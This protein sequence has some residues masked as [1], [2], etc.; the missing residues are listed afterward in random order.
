MT[1]VAQTATRRN[2]GGRYS[3]KGASDWYKAIEAENLAKVDAEQAALAALTAAAKEALPGQDARIDK[4]AALVAEHAVWPLTSGSYLVASQTDAQAAYL[5]QRPN[6]QRNGH[7][8][9]GWLCDC[10]DFQ[11]RGG[12]CG[13]IAATM[14]TVRM[15]ATY[16]PS[17][18]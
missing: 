18:N 4:G 2:E 9:H 15:G 16:E 8:G 10:K 3:A 1:N 13:H 6:D 12:L 17:Y 11:Y 5:V 14:L 7:G